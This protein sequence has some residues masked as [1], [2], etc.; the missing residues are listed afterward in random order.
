MNINNDFIIKN[1]GLYG[2]K[3]ISSVE[4]AINSLD[5]KIELIFREKEKD[6]V[7]S[8]TKNIQEEVIAKT[9]HEYTFYGWYPVIS[10]KRDSEGN[11]ILSLDD[12]N[13]L[14]YERDR[15]ERLLDLDNLEEAL[16]NALELFNEMINHMEDNDNSKKSSEKS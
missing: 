2:Q 3:T 9:L 14:Q 15:E 11:L 8:N 16:Q 13:T 1:F 6:F 7:L 5:K 12:K 10:D 4:K